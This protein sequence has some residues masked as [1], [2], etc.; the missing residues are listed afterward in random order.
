VATFKSCEHAVLALLSLQ[1]RI[2][3]VTKPGDDV[4][5]VSTNAQVFRSWWGGV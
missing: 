3:S 4:N 1:N 2:I 5:R